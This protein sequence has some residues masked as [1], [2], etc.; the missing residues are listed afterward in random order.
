MQQQ[1]PTQT[2]GSTGGGGGAGALFGSITKKLSSGAET[3]TRFT[4]A[5]ALKAEILMKE[6]SV[7]GVKQELGVTVYAA[8]ESGDQAEVARIFN[9][10]KA[11][12]D[13]LNAE[14]AAKRMEIT[15]LEKGSGAAS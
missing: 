15:E 14:I 8:L 3:A 13:A 7:K 5:Q 2:G 1:P 4:K 11:K 6:G 10:F 12:V 9:E